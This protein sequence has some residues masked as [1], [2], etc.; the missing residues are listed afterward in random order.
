MPKG[1]LAQ[2]TMGNVESPFKPDEFRDCETRGAAV[3]PVEHGRLASCGSTEQI[4]P[5]SRPDSQKVEAVSIPTYLDARIGRS[6][7]SGVL[8]TGVFQQGELIVAQLEF[9]AAQF[10][11]QAGTASSVSVI[12]RF[13]HA[14]GVVEHGEELNDFNVGIHESGQL[15]PVLEHA[16]PVSHA[17]NTLPG[18]RIARE[19]SIYEAGSDNIHVCEVLSGMQGM[20]RRPVY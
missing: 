15:A 20:E 5:R 6:Q 17:M 3:R 16:R 9:D 19:N 7:P 14:A 4:R 12:E 10:V 18:Q 2:A 8:A 1:T 13:V 11:R